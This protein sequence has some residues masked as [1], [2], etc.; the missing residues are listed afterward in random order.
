[1]VAGTIAEARARACL[2][3]FVNVETFIPPGQVILI[4][5]PP[6][7]VFLASDA[8]DHLIQVPD[9]VGLG[10]LRRPAIIVRS[11]FSSPLADCLIGHDNAAL[12]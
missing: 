7:P 12:E 5:G 11:E 3:P 9:I 1:L 4:D 10:S 8:D 6:E 2:S